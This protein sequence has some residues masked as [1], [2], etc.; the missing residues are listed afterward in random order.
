MCTPSPTPF[1]LLRAYL[2]LRRHLHAHMQP[3]LCRQVR[4]WLR[5]CPID[6]WDFGQKVGISACRP[7][8][9]SQNPPFSTREGSFFCLA[10]KNQTTLWPGTLGAA[11]S[12]CWRNGVPNA[13]GWQFIAPLL[14]GAMAAPAKKETRVRGC[15][16]AGLDS[17][18]PA[19]M[20]ERPDQPTITHPFVVP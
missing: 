19:V 16:L 12:A 4:R 1:L 18:T 2:R 13:G 8:E 17:F 14:W 10:L 5:P 20:I 11:H 7:P 15:G 9:R 6:F 3:M